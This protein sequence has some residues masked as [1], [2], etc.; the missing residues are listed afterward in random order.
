MINIYRYSN[1]LI[2][3]ESECLIDIEELVKVVN[4]Y[5]IEKKE[6]NGLDVATTRIGRNENFLVIGPYGSLNN[7]SLFD[8]VVAY[9][10]CHNLEYNDLRHLGCPESGLIL[11]KNIL[12]HVNVRKNEQCGGSLSDSLGIDA[13][14]A[15]LCKIINEFSGV[16]TFS[17]CEGH[18]FG[19][20]GTL[21]VLF[22]VDTLECLHPLSKSFDKN[23][24][25]LYE[26]YD[27]KKMLHELLLSFDYGHWPNIQRTYFEL[28]V[29][30][31]IEYQNDVF[32]RI[33]L[34]S[35]LMEED[36]K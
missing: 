2:L 36:L 14:V 12:P 13:G 25:V 35:E 27:F 6:L 21:Y 18:K 11:L 15:P 33:K 29:R 20:S 9:L 5:L 23:L 16:T 8:F 24:E 22:T 26:E 34:L 7:E 28:R 4:Y 3:E 10:E 19:N 32:K 30:Y 17:S 31:R 1:N